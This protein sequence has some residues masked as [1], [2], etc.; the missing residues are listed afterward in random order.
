MRILL[1]T[2]AATLAVV[3]SAA[4]GLDADVVVTGEIASFLTPGQLRD[5]VCKGSYDLVI[6][7]GM[8]TASFGEVEREFGVPIV[9]G[10]RHAA[11]LPFILP[12]LPGLTLSADIPADNLLDGM[13]REEAEKKIA[14]SEDEA[15]FEYLL[16]GVKIGGG[17]RIKV[18]AEIMDAHR[19][20]DLPGKVRDFFSRGAD[21]V[22]LGFGFD[23]TPEQVKRCFDLLEDIEGPLSV[24]SQDPS[25]ITAALGRADLVLSLQ[26][27]N[28]PLV[29]RGIADTGA[30]AVVV[31]GARGL[32]VNLEMARKAG[33][34]C[35]LADPLLVPAGSGIV[36][37]L[38][39]FSGHV[40]PLFFGAG[41]VVELLDADSPGA[42]AL[43]A[44]MAAETGAAVIFSSEHS[45]KTLGSVREMRRATEMM[46][47]AADRP[48][49]KD[50]GIDLLVI[51]EKRRRREPPLAY[52]QIIQARSMPREIEYDPCGNFRIGIEGEE[53]VA[54]L[55][56][57]AYRG[58]KWGDI[59]YT[60][61][62]EAEVSLL[63]HAAYLGKELYKA[64]LAIRFGRSYEQD[65]PF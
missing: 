56:N 29:G 54:V 17:S 42:N 1:P 58:K 60:I 2:G 45:D 50:L 51:K 11:D 49:P 46:Q 53:I 18:L 63:D 19:E 27:E 36:A 23:A 31:P 13:R 6:V 61:L 55:G 40:Y 39:G 10:P 44:A 14:R 32:S 34:E 41:N 24:D 65:G 8:C 21:I 7:P 37:S 28:I 43:L 25:L 30:G 26:E 20:T 22:D 64:E 38:S 12:L 4:A 59:F 3:Q 35:L 33:I 62:S 48:Y 5:L 57:R 47:L 52:T 15:G 16:R 9:R